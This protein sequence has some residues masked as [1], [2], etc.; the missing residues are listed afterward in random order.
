[1]L[2]TKYFPESHTASNISNII[3]NMLKEYN[4]PPEKVHGIITDNAANIK[5][6]VSD[7]GFYNQGC[8]LHTLQLVVNKAVLKQEG[9]VNIIKKCR[10][11][12]AHF[13]RS[14]LASIELKQMSISKL[15][16]GRKLILDVVTRWNSTYLMLQSC[17]NNK[18]S[19]KCCLVQND[20]EE[21]NLTDAQWNRLEAVSKVLKIFYDTT[22][23]MSKRREACSQIIPRTLALMNCINDMLKKETT[24]QEK[25]LP[26]LDNLKTFG[27]SLQT[28]M[29]HY[30][31]Q[32]L[33]CEILAV[34][35]FM[36][37]R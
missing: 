32:Y 4:I 6:G 28:E 7:S 13:H 8:F 10:A 34:A 30:F 17:L 22:L 25:Q 33:E 29:K 21:M 3:L 11:L 9:V 36:D 19:I 20:K 5:R 31:G 26:K 12:V 1:M 23:Q 27:K 15:E 2:H 14:T 37:P 16:G 24:S 18:K 35:T